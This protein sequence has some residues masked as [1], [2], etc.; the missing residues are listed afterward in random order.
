MGGVSWWRV[1][2][3]DPILAVQLEFHLAICGQQSNGFGSP[4]EPRA[5]GLDIGIDL[6]E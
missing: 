1:R 3:H 5:H 6:A 2:F 4:V